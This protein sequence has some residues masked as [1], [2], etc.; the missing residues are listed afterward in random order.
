[1]PEIDFTKINV[2]KL[3]EEFGLHPHFLE[4]LPDSL[5]RKMLQQ[6]ADGP[7]QLLG[8]GPHASAS[9]YCGGIINAP[10][11]TSI[12]L[13]AA[14]WTVPQLSWPSATGNKTAIAS[15]WIGIDGFL[16][17][18]GG[19]LIGAFPLFQ[20]GIQ[21]QIDVDAN[22]GTVQTNHAFREFVHL[23]QTQ[24]S[25]EL[26]E[27]NLWDFDVQANDTINVA[28]WALQ[29]GIGG[30]Y[31]MFNERTGQHFESDVFGPTGSAPLR[32]LTASW[33]VERPIEN[34]RLSGLDG[35]PMKLADFGTLEFRSC[36]AFVQSPGSSA[37]PVGFLSKFA[38]LPALECD[39]TD[40]FIIAHAEITGNDTVE[41]RFG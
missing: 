34:V 38:G 9:T 13:I 11:G 12:T 22:G 4:L 25:T 35:D 15:Q 36:G 8:L 1:M 32:G 18:A 24:P 17:T 2:R 3:A 14:S 26:Y 6:L 41:C 10:A 37:V 7:K 40:L 20:V 30:A 23:G 33:I 19:P 5:L 16:P 31:W 27:P 29:G 39:M 21:S 28:I